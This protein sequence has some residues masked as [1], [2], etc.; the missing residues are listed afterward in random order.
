MSIVGVNVQFY[1]RE[2][3]VGN[4][5]ESMGK[6]APENALEF[7]PSG[8]YRHDYAKYNPVDRSFTVVDESLPHLNSMV[9]PTEPQRPVEDDLKNENGQII[10]SS[11]M[12]A[13]K[14]GKEHRNVLQLIKNITTEKSVLINKYYMPS[15]YRTGTGKSYKEYL[16]NRD[17][18]TLLAMGFTG[19]EALQFKLAYIEAF[20][21]MEEALKNQTHNYLQHIEMLL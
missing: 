12:V 17:G 15:T 2:I 3:A 10:V 21:K 1:D 18:F 8:Q 20:N 14:F 4:V 9:E 19:K 7:R 16:M 13:E 5:T 11:R 6:P